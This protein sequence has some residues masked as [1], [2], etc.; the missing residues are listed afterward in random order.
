MK[1]IAT[2]AEF[3]DLIK[4]KLVEVG[5]SNSNE[6]K[7]L[8]YSSVTGKK[9]EV[10]IS[11]SIDDSNQLEIFEED[12]S[13]EDKGHANIEDWI[14]DWRIAWK[15]KRNKAMGSRDKC[16]E[17][18]KEFFQLYPEYTKDHVF[19]AR[20]KY[21][22]SLDGDYTYLEQA[23]FFIKKRVISNDGKFE[24]RKTLLSYAEEVLFDE[25]LIKTT[26]VN[27]FEE[28]DPW[29]DVN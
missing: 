12:K 22:H 23:D 21:L 15:G 19:K 18:M 24:I 4:K 16:I 8:L 2:K 5:I 1:V 29:E 17:N 28:F 6:Y 26:G 14:N 10:P 9:F 13:I 25:E 3:D 11:L 20:D 7:V 27:H